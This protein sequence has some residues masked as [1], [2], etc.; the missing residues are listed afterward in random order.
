MLDEPEVQQYTPEEIK[1]ASAGVKFMRDTPDY[2]PCPENGEVIEQYLEQ[3][4]WEP[5]VQHMVEAHRVLSNE[6]LLIPRPK[7]ARERQRERLASQQLSAV[8][9][10]QQIAAEEEA[11]ELQRRKTMPLSELKKLTRMEISRNQKS[12]KDG[13]TRTEYP[14]GKLGTKSKLI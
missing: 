5:T 2:Y 8:E 1:L 12:P 4:G 13:I 7:S 10:Q 9:E 3:R 11:A 6:G 14:V